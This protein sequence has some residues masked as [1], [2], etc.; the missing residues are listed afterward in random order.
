MNNNCVL[1]CIEIVSATK[2]YTLK[3]KLCSC[4][5]VN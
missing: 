4:L 2:I 3:Q 5:V 1:V